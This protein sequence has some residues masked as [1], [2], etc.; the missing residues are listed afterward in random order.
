M[1]Q[2]RSKFI[3]TESKKT[4][5]MNLAFILL[6]IIYTTWLRFSAMRFLSG[7]CPR[8]QMSCMG[9]YRRNVLTLYYT[10]LYLIANMFYRVASIVL[11]DYARQLSPAAHFWIWNVT[12][13][14]WGEGSYLVLPWILTVPD[15]GSSSGP[16]SQFYVRKPELQPRTE[17]A[18][19]L[20][21][22]ISTVTHVIH[23][24]EYVKVSPSHNS[25]AEPD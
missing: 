11:A 6:V 19:S 10:Y 18:I 15:S 8:G 9:K 23:V 2:H 5:I 13:A 20:R 16:L 21:E 1:E 25:H 22:K 7:L 24:E 12:A 14:I 4:N 17:N 3:H